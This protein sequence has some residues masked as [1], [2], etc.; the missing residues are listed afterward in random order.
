M[1]VSAVNEMKMYFW[2][3]NGVLYILNDLLRVGGASYP[4]AIRRKEKKR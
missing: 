1:F 4:A 2:S 3:R